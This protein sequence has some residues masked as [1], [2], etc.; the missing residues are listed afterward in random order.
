MSSDL[1]KNHLNLI[2][3]RLPS[4][5]VKSQST[6]QKSKKLTNIIGKSYLETARQNESYKQQ[7]IVADIDIL[8]QK[9][10]KKSIKKKKRLLKLNS[11]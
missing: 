1:L 4:K 9:S 11:N 6:K 8:A 3:D 10:K 7:R 2:K 5:A